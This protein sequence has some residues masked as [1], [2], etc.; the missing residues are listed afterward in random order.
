MSQKMRSHQCFVLLFPYFPHEDDEV[1]TEP[2]DDVVLAE[3]AQELER[4]RLEL[5]GDPSA[6][7][8]GF[9]SAYLSKTIDGGHRAC[10][11]GRPSSRAQRVG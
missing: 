1:A 11:C 6:C 7:T 9:R 5:A 4:R 8:E 2:P 10:R 3:L